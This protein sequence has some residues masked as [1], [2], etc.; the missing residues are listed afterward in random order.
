MIPTRS[1]DLVRPRRT[2]DRLAS[3]AVVLALSMAAIPV[4]G[5]AAGLPSASKGRTSFAL[6]DLSQLSEALGRGEL[7]VELLVA[8]SLVA[9]AVGFAL[10]LRVG[11]LRPRRRRSTPA[12][13]PAPAESS[14]DVL[15][16]RTTLPLPAQD[17]EV[18]Q[19]A[20]SPSAA[21]A[22]DG[23]Q[24]TLFRQDGPNT[25]LDAA[26]AEAWAAREATS[27]VARRP[28]AWSPGS[29]PDVGHEDTAAVPEPALRPAPAGAAETTDTGAFAGGV[30]SADAGADAPPT[31]ERTDL[32]LPYAAI[33]AIA[34][35]E[36]P[37][38]DI[39]SARSTLGT[40]EAPLVVEL[41][42]ERE[43]RRVGPNLPLVAAIGT[44]AVGVAFS[45]GAA[46]GATLGVG[47]GAAIG[48]AFA[49]GAGA[50]IGATIALLGGRRR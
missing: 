43:S 22:L 3:V 21:L 42:D 37:R 24:P 6:L 18:L 33:A 19:P 47:V 17:V 8:G 23:E 41:H 48:L 40:P 49:G 38:A 35:R 4:T 32:P 11:A 14:K 31:W 30:G 16:A 9:L 36:V 1:R 44:V 7:P 34:P 15:D 20:S 28:S 10:T 29:R 26:Q 46:V 13:G 25:P 45:T 27:E 2:V 39:P 50:A 12:P 5:F